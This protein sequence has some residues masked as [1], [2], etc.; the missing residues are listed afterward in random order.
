MISIA[1]SGFLESIRDKWM[2]TFMNLPIRRQ[3][4]KQM[5]WKSFDPLA[6]Y[7]NGYNS[8]RANNVIF[9]KIGFKTKFLTDACNDGWHFYKFLVVLFMGFSSIFLS[10]TDIYWFWKI[11]SIIPIGIMWNIGFNL[12]WNKK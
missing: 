8:P 5:T 7:S 10:L 6:K 1:F 3:Q 9:E 11:L 4:T 12:N 2:V